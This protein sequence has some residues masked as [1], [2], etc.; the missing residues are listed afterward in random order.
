M[1]RI[2]HERVGLSAQRL[3]ARRICRREE[4]ADAPVLLLEVV[5]EAAQVLC[6]IGAAH[7]PSRGRQLLSL[8]PIRRERGRERGALVADL[9]ERAADLRAG[10][11]SSAAARE[12]EAEGEGARTWNGGKRPLSSRRATSTRTSSGLW[13][14]SGAPSACGE[15]VRESSLGGSARWEGEDAPVRMMRLSGLG[16]GT[17]AALPVACHCSSFCARRAGRA[18]SAS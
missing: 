2:L 12:G 1:S 4:H 15:S 13:P 10:A 16:R 18:G 5:V 3:G 17:P 6:R 8:A 11:G 9:D 7:G 14:L